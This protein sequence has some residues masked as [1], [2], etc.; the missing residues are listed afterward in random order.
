MVTPD[1]YAVLLAA[2]GAGVLSSRV[3][4][5]VSALGMTSESQVEDLLDAMEDWRYDSDPWLRV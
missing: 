1:D 5:L 3:R 2:R 4:G